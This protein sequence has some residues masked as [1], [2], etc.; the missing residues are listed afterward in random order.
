MKHTKKKGFTLIELVIVI[1]VIAILAGV[2]IATFSNVVE[3]AQKSA[4]LQEAKAMIDAA[5]V[6]YLTEKNAAPTYVKFDVNSEGK[7]TNVD[8]AGTATEG[9]TALSDYTATANKTLGTKSTVVFVW[10][11][12]KGYSVLGLSSAS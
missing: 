3:K 4:D 11:T 9:Y 7:L 6:N 10:D 8:F 5:Y 12:E 1:A 2:M